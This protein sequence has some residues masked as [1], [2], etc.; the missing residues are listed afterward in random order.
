MMLIGLTQ[1][2]KKYSFFTSSEFPTACPRGESMF[3]MRAAVLTPRLLNR[4]ARAHRRR[5][6]I[7]HMKRKD[8]MGGKRGITPT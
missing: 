4:V 7:D 6:G 8:G 1:A 3:V 5:Q 2:S